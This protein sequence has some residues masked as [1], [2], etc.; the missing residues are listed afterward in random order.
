MIWISWKRFA[1]KTHFSSFFDHKVNEEDL[2][3]HAKYWFIDL[4]NS[5]AFMKVDSLKPNMK[6]CTGMN[7]HFPLVASIF[8]KDYVN[9][10][11]S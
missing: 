7:F 3:L 1:F 11:R 8:S 9:I 10:Q 2:H 4:N 5:H 6:S